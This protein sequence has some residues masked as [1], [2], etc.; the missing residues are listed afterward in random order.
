MVATLRAGVV[1][2]GVFGGFH[3]AKYAARADVSLTAVFDPHPE[4]AEALAIRFGATPAPDLAALLAEIDVLSIVSP[5]HTHATIALAALAAGKHL[6]IEKPIA[7]FLEDA[8]A[9]VATG[10]RRGV[11]VAC[12]FL[13]RAAFRAMNLFEVPEAPL[14]ME[15]VRRGPPSPR[16]LDV[17]VVMD[18]MIHDLDL[19]LALSAAPALAVEAEGRRLANRSFDEVEAEI[20]FEGG[21]TA[22]LSA[23]R[24]AE[25]RERHMRLVYP[26]GE[27]RIDFLAHSFEN[28]TPLPLN[29]AFEETPAGKDRLG[30]S[31]GA[32]LA[33]V[34]GQAPAPLADAEDGARA[35]DL[36]LAVEQ[37]VET[38]A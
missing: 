3:A 7:T 36:A 33:A 13:E 20:T 5:A 38:A 32:F 30:A 23:S 27:V 22:S 18:L 15:A 4:R 10:R 34:R 16:S 28:T 1:G 24:V 35:L 21:F 14:R 8:D 11:I 31:I 26:S 2:A 37:A 12:G 9:I 17:S 29:S 19:A 25:G 6:Y